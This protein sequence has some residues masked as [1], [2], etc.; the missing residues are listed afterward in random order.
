M[1]KRL[2]IEFAKHVPAYELLRNRGLLKEQ[3]DDVGVV[4]LMDHGLDIC[5][6]RRADGTTLYLTR[7][8]VLR[9]IQ[10]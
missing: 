3:E 9:A 7:D 10:L 8:V 6:L 2:G 1:H 5:A 4:D